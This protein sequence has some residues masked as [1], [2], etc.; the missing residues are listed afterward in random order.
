MSVPDL[1][2]GLM[3]GTSLDGVDAVLVDFSPATPVLRATAYLPYPAELRC[4]LL[5]LHQPQHNELHQAAMLSQKLARIYA[6]AVFRTLDN[7]GIPTT[8]VRA[9]GCHGQTI[10]H[11]PHLGYTIQINNPALLAKLTSISV[12]ADFRS[13]DIAAGGQGAPLV[14]AFHAALFRD[15]SRHRVIV[16]IGGIANLTDLKPGQT[17]RGFDYG[18]GNMLLDAWT[19]RHLGQDY[20]AG[21][22][23]A[24][25][26]Q[27]LPDLLS[28]LLGHPFFAEEPPKSCGREQFNLDWLSTFL[29]D[30][31]IPVDVQATLLTLTA[32]ATQLAVQR[33][34][35]FVDEIYVCGGGAHNS[36]LLNKLAELMPKVS[37]S[38]TDALGLPADWVEAVAFAWIARRTMDGLPG[39]LPEVTGA[40]EERLLG[41]IYPA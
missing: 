34:C 9:I 12:V 39:N 6:D 29:T 11:Q 24:A 40:R 26:G 14:P 21:G 41:A 37:I 38:T 13:R 32:N 17:T 1:I 5:K 15:A 4:D 36:A 23:W 16:N 3:S 18:P 8:A 2:V 35:G 33:W 19:Q 31:D 20:D 7:A 30:A 28:R 10:R 22:Q 25:S 27:V